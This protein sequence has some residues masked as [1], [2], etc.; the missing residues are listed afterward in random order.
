[1]HKQSPPEEG[2]CIKASHLHLTVCYLGVQLCSATKFSS[3]LLY[4][5][6]WPYYGGVSLWSAGMQPV[7]L[8]ALHGFSSQTDFSFCIFLALLLPRKLVF[9]ARKKPATRS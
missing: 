9:H 2:E 5:V 7:L 8:I 4:M 3:L 6:P 1:M